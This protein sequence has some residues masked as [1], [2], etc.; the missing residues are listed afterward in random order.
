MR[1]VG[2]ERYQLTFTS[3]T[4]TVL[5]EKG[6]ERFSGRATSDLPN[7]IN[8]K[9]VYVGT[10]KQSVRNRLRYGWSAKGKGGYYGYA[11]RHGNSQA[12]LDVWCHADAMDRNERDIGTVEAEVVFLIRAAGQWPQFQT[13]IHFYPSAPHHRRAAAKILAHYKI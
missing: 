10:T 3:K 13:E 4:F 1:I 12:D 2:P 8:N 5:C 11:W 6:T 7:S 9:P